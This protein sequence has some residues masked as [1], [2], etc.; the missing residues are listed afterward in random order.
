M[1]NTKKKQK[2]PQP[3]EYV[4]RTR[5]QEIRRQFVKNKGAVIALWGLIFLFIV[6][7]FAQFYYDFE[8]DICQVTS[9]VLK[10]PS[11]EHPFGTDQLGRDVLA[12]LLY[13]GRWSISI[14]L[15]S[16]IISS[17]AGILYGAIATYIGGKVETVMMRII[18]SV[19]MIPS[20]LLVIVLVGVLG[21]S[22]VNL[23]VAM[24]LG[25]IPY[26]ARLTRS[27]IMPIRD[28]DYVEAARAIG[29]SDVR[30]LFS[31]ILPNCLSP[32][33]VNITVRTGVSVVGVA[34]YS[35]LGLG[36]AQPIPE[37]GAML[38]EARNFMSVRPDLVFYPGIMIL[39]FTLLFNLLGDG[40]RD[41][42]DPKLKR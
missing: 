13:G 21:T 26:L 25:G 12:R 38:S 10:P 42:L 22:T 11:W 3:G 19:M 18:E 29:V 17:T 7:V 4:A 23:M 31:H 32:L 6:L 2:T 15:G 9:N 33:I 20:M 40:L 16:V 37:W 28:I 39:I 36:V 14:A 30:I 24:S 1:I 35:F 5:F 34:T 8:T 41:A 27:V